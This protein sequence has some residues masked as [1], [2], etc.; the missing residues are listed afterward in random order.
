MHC[1]SMKEKE[2][3]VMTPRYKAKL[4]RNIDVYKSTKHNESLIRHNRSTM[5]LRG[6]LPT[7]K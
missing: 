6:L 7:R 4:E 3:P 2:I 5:M 1:E